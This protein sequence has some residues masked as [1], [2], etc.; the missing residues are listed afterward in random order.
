MLLR[1]IIIICFFVGT[2]GASGSQTGP[3]AAT[4]S[5]T[6]PQMVPPTSATLPPFLYPPFPMIP[7]SKYK[8]LHIHL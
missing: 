3:S 2:S 7:F 5:Q 6:A 1:I 8:S 4:G